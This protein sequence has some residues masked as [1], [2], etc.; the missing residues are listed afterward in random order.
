MMKAILAIVALAACGGGEDPP[1]DSAPSDTPGQS[2][3]MVVTPCTGEAAT[4]TSLAA[5][6]DPENT[7][8]TMGQIVKM[9]AE[10]TGSDDHNI[11]PALSGNT[12]P[13]LVVPVG[14]TKCF[15]FTA[16]GTFGF[17]CGIHSFIGTITVN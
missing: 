2:S 14:Q 11:M 17:R 15:R 4:V 7:T 16:T 3:V 8:I 10:S 1:A 12:D 9:V 5:R 13:A 6:F